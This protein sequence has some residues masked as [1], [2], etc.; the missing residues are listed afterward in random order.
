MVRTPDQALKQRRRREILRAAT[1]CFV[2]RGFHRTT[3]DQICV[4][5]GL[6]PGTV[7]R[8]FSSKHAIVESIAGAELAAVAEL[9]EPLRDSD[10]FVG[11][12]IGITERLV[13]APVNMD[14]ARLGIEIIAEASRNPRVSRVLER[15]GVK[16]RSVLEQAAQRARTLGQIDPSLAPAPL[17]ELLL[18]LIEGVVGRALF[19]PRYDRRSLARSFRVLATRFLRPSMRVAGSALRQGTRAD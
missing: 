4:T 15:H 7:Y 19:N 5:A 17:A 12:F 8:Y 16:V 9:I 3:M 6:S 1:R 2:R 14:E 13:L 10:D 11:D 18:A